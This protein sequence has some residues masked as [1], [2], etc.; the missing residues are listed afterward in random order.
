MLTDTQIKDLDKEA[1]L[2]LCVM[3]RQP[4]TFAKP[5]MK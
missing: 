2:S 4:E 3:I 5:E 1:R